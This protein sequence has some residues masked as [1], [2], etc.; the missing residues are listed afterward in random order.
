MD[1][2]KK[3]VHEFTDTINKSVTNIIKAIDERWTSDEQNDFRD[4]C[5]TAWKELGNEQL[6]REFIKRSYPIVYGTQ[7]A[8]IMYTPSWSAI[9]E[10][11]VRNVKAY[12]EKNQ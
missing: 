9:E 3:T 4:I 8:T 5:I 10:A 7:I 2:F 1:I 11:E 6:Y 12:F